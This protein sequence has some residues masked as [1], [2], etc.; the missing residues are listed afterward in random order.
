[1]K[2]LILTSLLLAGCSGSQQP[3]PAQIAAYSSAVHGV[4]QDAA[5]DYKTI[6]AV[7]K[8]K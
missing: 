5:S 1:M 3:T 6:K 2:L 7:Q 4:V 8:T